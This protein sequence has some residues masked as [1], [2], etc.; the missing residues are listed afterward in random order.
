V[1]VPFL[2]ALLAPYLSFKV[3]HFLMLFYSFYYILLE[4]IA[5]LLYAP[6]LATMVIGAELFVLSFP[7]D[8]LKYSLIIHVT[9]W[10]SQFIGH[11]IFEKRRPALMDNLAQAFLLAPFFVFM[12]VLFAL[13]YRPLL[14]R[15][16]QS[17]V[18]KAIEEWKKSKK[19][20]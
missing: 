2:S 11:G 17:K 9:S 20:D 12:E 15:R 14:H 5:G 16:I 4:P 3:S 7:E 6:I 1:Q 19:S 8:Y 10:V 18:D 13:G